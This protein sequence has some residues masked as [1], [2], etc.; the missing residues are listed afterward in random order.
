MSIER[1]RPTT[2]RKVCAA[3]VLMDAGDV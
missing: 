1:R 3:L 2:D